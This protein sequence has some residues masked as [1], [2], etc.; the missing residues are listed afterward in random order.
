VLNDTPAA[1]DLADASGAAIGVV[2]PGGSLSIREA[3]VTIGF[4]SITDQGVIMTSDAFWSPNT[5]QRLSWPWEGSPRI[6]TNNAYFHSIAQYAG[7]GG[8]TVDL[9]QNDN[10]IRRVAIVIR[11]E[12]Q[13][14]TASRRISM[15]DDGVLIDDRWQVRISPF[16]G[17]L[18]LGEEPSRGRFERRDGTSVAAGNGAAFALLELDHSDQSWTITVTDLQ[19]A[20]TGETTQ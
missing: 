13:S 10:R 19:Q 4:W 5:H 17:A 11:T 18:R 3:G 8:W 7:D 16:A 9:S 6:D 12:A 14:E 20:R 1:I 15:S 2:S